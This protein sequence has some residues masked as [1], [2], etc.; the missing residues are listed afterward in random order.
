MRKN[1]RK[2]SPAS[3]AELREKRDVCSLRSLARKYGVSHE[4]VRRAL[5]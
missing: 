3:V 5:M 4:S 2:L 1:A